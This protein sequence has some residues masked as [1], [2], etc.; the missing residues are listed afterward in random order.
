VG[1]GIDI[2][3]KIVG[4]YSPEKHDIHIEYSP[5]RISELIDLLKKQIEE[6]NTTG[7]EVIEAQEVKLI[8]HDDEATKPD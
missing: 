2:A 4:E 7:D 5:A 8:G 6:T 3:N 1:K